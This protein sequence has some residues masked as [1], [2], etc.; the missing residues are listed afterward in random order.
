[1]KFTNLD[2]KKNYMEEEIERLRLDIVKLYSEKDNILNEISDQRDGKQVVARQSEI[3]K[4]EISTVESILEATREALY[5]ES[6]HF[7]NLTSKQK[8][9]IQELNTAI[10]ERLDELSLQEGKE[11]IDFDSENT[12]IKKEL[13]KARKELQKAIDDA[14]SL[15]SE[16]IAFDKEKEDIQ[17]ALDEERAKYLD[18]MGSLEK[19]EQKIILTE[20]RL[21]KYKKELL[22]KK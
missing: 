12:K 6:H 16:R 13:T 2:Q 8:D 10:Q 5:K 15:K 21:E 17:Q 11:L 7:Y 19:R 4:S 18:Y 9:K 3:I 20:K 14:E 1:M 22:S